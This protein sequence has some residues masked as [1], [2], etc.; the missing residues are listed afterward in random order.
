MISAILKHAAAR[1]EIPGDRDWSLVADVVTAVGLMQIINGQ[2][3]DADFVRQVIDTLVL[4]AVLA[5]VAKLERSSP[6]VRPSVEGFVGS[7]VRIMADSNTS[8]SA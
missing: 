4:P 8:P 7:R 1:G 2:T 3:V 5:P 6:P